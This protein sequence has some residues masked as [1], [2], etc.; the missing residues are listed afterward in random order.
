MK[1]CG[2]NMEKVLLISKRKKAKYL[3]EQKGWSIRKI[4]KYLVSCKNNVSR[5]VKMSEEEIDKDNRG[6]TAGQLRN[7][8]LEAKERIKTFR[9][10]LINEGSYFYGAPVIKENYELKYGE[11]I[12]LWFVN[13]TLK[14][15]GMVKSP[16]P[17]Q[18]GKSKYMHYPLHTLNKLCKTLMSIDFIGPKYLKGSDKRINFLSCKYIRPNKEGI[19]ERV[20][21]QTSEETIR[22]LKKI[23]RE[24]P[25]P[26]V[27][28]VDNDSA[29]GTNLSHELCVGKTTLFLLNSG[30]KPLYVAPRSPWNN[31]EVEGFNSIFSK[32]FWKSIK[33][34]D[35][36][37][38]DIEIKNFNMEYSKY[39]KLINNN[40]SLKKPVFIHDFSTVNLENKQMNKFKTDKIYF[41]RIVRRLGEKGEENEKG[42]IELLG[43]K[44][45][46]P[47]DLINLFV[48]CEIAL[49][50]QK[51]IISTETENGQLV[52]IKEQKMRIRNII[53]HKSNYD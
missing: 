53:Y 31:G 9:K 34:T 45:P 5:W 49:K 44:I 7:N 22:V 4:A 32:K 15:Y 30:V 26:D 20:S 3:F 21:G 35:E 52:K 47:Q 41:L 2:A 13:N 8:T 17:Y 28:K 48:F 6:W 16:Q 37:D 27:L 12:S 23:W 18:S 19:V 1:K 40:V 10:K 43:K 33:F 51:L 38:I 11:K 14:E 25:L 42:F 36:D 29:F 24:H 50:D 46:L 39:S